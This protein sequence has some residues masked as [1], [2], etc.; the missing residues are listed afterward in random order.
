MI[1]KL[2]FPD[3]SS[4]FLTTK[5]IL[6]AKDAQPL[7]TNNY[8]YIIILLYLGCMMSFV[9]MDIPKLYNSISFGPNKNRFG[10]FD[11]TIKRS[12]S[13]KGIRNRGNLNPPFRLHKSSSV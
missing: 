4:Q 13:T 10:Q 2:H 8:D 7:I 3:V 6:N 9:Q 1:L 12:I 11:Q 5:L